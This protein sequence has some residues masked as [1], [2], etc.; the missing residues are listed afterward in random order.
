MKGKAFSTLA[1]TLILAISWILVPYNPVKAADNYVNPGDSIQAAIDSASAYDTIIL[2]PGIYENQWLTID[3]PLTIQGTDKTS[4]ILRA[5][6]ISSKNCMSVINTTDVYISNLTFDNYTRG[7]RLEN[8]AYSQVADNSFINAR[9]NLAADYC[10]IDMLFATNSIISGNYFEENEFGIIL[11]HSTNNTLE[12]NVVLASEN[13]NGI[14]MNASSNN[15]LANNE[16]AHGYSHGIFM[17]YNSNGNSIIDNDIHDNFSGS[18]IFTDFCSHNTFTANA[19]YNNRYNGVFIYNTPEGNMIADNDI[20]DNG[21]SGVF[22]NTNSANNTIVSNSICNNAENGIYLYQNVTNTEIYYNTIENN[23]E[24]MRLMAAHY[25]RAYNNNFINNA[26]YWQAE[27]QSSAAVELSLPAPVGGNYWSNHNTPDSDL[28]GFVDNPY[29]IPVS[30]TDYLPWAEPDGWLSMP[31]PENQAP[32]ANPGGP[33]T[34]ILGNAVTLDGSASYDPD[35]AGGDY[36]SIYHWDIA[37][38]LTLEGET[39]A[40]TAENITALGEGIHTVSLTVMDSLEASSTNTTTLEV[41]PPPTTVSEDL[42]ELIAYFDEAVSDGTL[43]GL[44][45]GKSAG[46]RLGALRNML[47]ATENLVEDG[48]TEEAL[49]QLQSA[50]AKVDSDPK[51]PD[52]ATGDAAEE[53]AAMILEII[54]RL[55]GA[56][57]P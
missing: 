36:I 23:D 52:F 16:I 41:L 57:A 38:V 55:Q 50:Y 45:P 3:K 39:P 46:G 20:Y 11:R 1:I 22:I 6:I 4:T 53:I 43:E 28:D 40:V 19:I 31:T 9:G 12:N 18:G 56:V 25:T 27:A 34:I 17:N 14:W 44:G 2:N 10:G 37:G 48:Q 24:G 51:P 54:E 13:G 49:E 7:V 26:Y 35:A 42:E 29:S 21:G 47:E 5:T 8:T 33:Y 30:T 32:V 15:T